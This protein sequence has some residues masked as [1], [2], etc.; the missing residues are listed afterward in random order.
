MC[1][2]VNDNYDGVGRDWLIKSGLIAASGQGS[3]GRGQNGLPDPVEGARS[4]GAGKAEAGQ[5]PA[6]SCSGECATCRSAS[7]EG[8]G[9]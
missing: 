2:S 6:G 8:E 3:D 7:A 1:S 4:Q 9:E 5:R